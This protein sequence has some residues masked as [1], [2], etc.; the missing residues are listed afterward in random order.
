MSSAGDALAEYREMIAKVAARVEVDG[1]LPT[2]RRLA[3]LAGG[4]AGAC[5]SDE[6]TPNDDRMLRD[7]ARLLERAAKLL[8]TLEQS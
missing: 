8:A 6:T 3:V 1:L 7:A 5:V 4:A 2:A